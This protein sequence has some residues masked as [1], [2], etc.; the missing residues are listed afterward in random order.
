MSVSIGFVS[1]DP[2][3]IGSEGVFTF[4]DPTNTA[5]QTA[6]DVFQLS[7]IAQGTTV[8]FNFASLPGDSDFGVFLC[9]NSDLSINSVSSTQVVDSVGNI[10][11]GVP[12]TGTTAGLTSSA[13]F[14]T[15]TP[16]GTDGLTY[17]FD[18]VGLP[19]GWT[20]YATDGN[21]PL[22]PSPIPEP[23]TFVLLG[24]GIVGLAGF[25]RRRRLQA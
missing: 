23:S 22:P 5:D 1:N 16:S 2:L 18:G 10:M 3:A 25:A 11:T 14:A 13:T 12:C 8:T 4:G 19:D 24:T 20:F 21:L 9:A 7:G 15:V 6:Y 17:T